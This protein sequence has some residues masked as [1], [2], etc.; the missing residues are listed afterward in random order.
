MTACVCGFNVLFMCYATKQNNFFAAF[1]K[2]L[3]LES[4]SPV[5]KPSTFLAERFTGRKIR[6]GTPKLKRLTSQGH[7]WNWVGAARNWLSYALL[8]ACI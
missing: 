5:L 2:E 7:A 4:D 1:G 8:H 3:E 6:G